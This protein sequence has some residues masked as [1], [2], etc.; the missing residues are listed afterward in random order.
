[1]T[2][3]DFILIAVMLI[4]CALICAS[5][6][7]LRKIS[8]VY[9]VVILIC[10]V[11]LLYESKQGVTSHLIS[12]VIVCLLT[13]T[14]FGFK[15]LGGGDVKLMIAFSIAIPIHYLGATIF[16]VAIIGGALAL[17]YLLKYRILKLVPESGEAGLPYGL[18]ISFG[19][20]NTV[21]NLY[22]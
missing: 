2:Q 10:S 20:F 11:L 7:A 15:I 16:N 19:F 21:C 22:V 1:M 3:F 9:G 13:L 5:D 6:V 4:T 17:F 8:N 14:A 18:A 12:V